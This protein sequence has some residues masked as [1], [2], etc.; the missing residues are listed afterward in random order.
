MIEEYDKKLNEFN[1]YSINMWNIDNISDVDKKINCPKERDSLKCEELLVDDVVDCELKQ[2]DDS[3]KSVREERIN[4]LRDIY[5]RDELV[6]FLGAGVS[7]DA[8]ISEW[9]DLVY[10]LLVLMIKDILE[11]KNVKISKKETIFLIDK[12]KELNSQ[13]PL[14]Q[15]AFIKD[16]LGE[17]FKKKLS[18]ILYKN[19][20]NDGESKLLDSISKLCLP[21]R[22]GVG[23]QA[24]VTYNFDDLLEHNFNRYNIEYQSL[25]NDFD[26]VTSDKLGIYHVHGFLPTDPNEYEQLGEELLVFSEDAYHSLYNDPYSWA[27]ITQLNFLR[28][29]T[30]LMIGL[31]LTDPNLRRLLSIRN[32]KN[33]LKKHYAIMK[34]DNFVKDYNDKEIKEEILKSFNIINTD[35]QENFFEKLG[36]NVIWIEDYDEIPSIIESIR[37]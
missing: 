12:M 4:D 17:S 33:K 30:T 25:Y 16:V 3:W 21:K 15:V 35:L 2:E 5:R 10:D 29:N 26:Y 34:K 13:S 37:S 28:E 31:S 7:K 19:I 1:K 14:L 32:K 20:V 27:N 23:I 8:G 9:K 22:N 18:E 6:L 11:K 36:I 24:V